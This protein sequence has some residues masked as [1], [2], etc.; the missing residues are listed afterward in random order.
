[1]I[2]EAEFLTNPPYF[3]FNLAIEELGLDLDSIRQN[4]FHDFVSNLIDDYMKL[5]KAFVMKDLTIFRKQA[6]KIKGVAL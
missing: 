1:M 5:R 2:N 6:H 4:N 3:N